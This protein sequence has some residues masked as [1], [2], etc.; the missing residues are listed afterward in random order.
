MTTTPSD[1]ALVLVDRVEVTVMY[2]QV[3]DNVEEIREGWPRLEQIIGNLRGRHF[4]ATV[5]P[6]LD[7][8]RPSV[9]WREGDEAQPL[10]LTMG[11]VPGGRY[12]RARLRGEPPELYDRIA[13]TADLLERSATWD[14]ARPLIEA[15]KRHD[16]VDVLLPVANAG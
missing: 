3:G 6:E 16:L 5:H 2:L 11:V 7:A 8:Y 14:T 13:P 4:L 12:L 15:Y 1:L 9:Q 10:G